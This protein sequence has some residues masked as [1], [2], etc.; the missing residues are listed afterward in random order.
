VDFEEEGLGFVFIKGRFFP[1]L[2][3]KPD[4]AW[5][6]AFPAL[7]KFRVLKKSTVPPII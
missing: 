2:R 4:R 3:Q 7:W 5:M 1:I 6:L